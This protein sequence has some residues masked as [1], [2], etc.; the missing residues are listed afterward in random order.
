[1]QKRATKGGETGMN[2]EFYAG[3]TYLPRTSLTK[4]AKA[5]KRAGSRKVEI[6]PFKWVEAREG[7][8]PIFGQFPYKPESHPEMRDRGPGYRHLDSLYTAWIDGGRWVAA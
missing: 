2:G 5:S 7:F 1:M 3:G 6:E 8:R 4:M